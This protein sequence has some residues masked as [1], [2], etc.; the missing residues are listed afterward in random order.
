MKIKNNRNSLDKIFFHPE[1]FDS[2]DMKERDKRLFILQKNIANFNNNLGNSLG[3]ME[4][5]I[6]KSIISYKKTKK[7]NNNFLNPTAIS[8]NV[9]LNEEKVIKRYGSLE[10]FISKKNSNSNFD[11][12]TMSSSKK[13]GNDL[14][15]HPFTSLR[16]KNQK[17]VE[18]INKKQEN[19]INNKYIQNIFNTNRTSTFETDSNLPNV[20]NFNLKNKTLKKVNSEPKNYYRNKINMIIKD[21]KNNS[22]LNDKINNIIIDNYSKKNYLPPIKLKKEYILDLV[23]SPIHKN[24]L[25]NINDSSDSNFSSPSSEFNIFSE[26]N[27][28]GDNS[29]NSSK[30]NNNKSK[31]KNH[32]NITTESLGT[33]SSGNKDLSNIKDKIINLFNNNNF[34]NTSKFNQIKTIIKVGNKLNKKFKKKCFYSELNDLIMRSKIKYTQWRYGVPDA[35]KYFVDLNKFKKKEETEL[36]NRK[37][38]YEKA[39][40][41]IKEVNED[42]DKKKSVDISQKYGNKIDNKKKKDKDKEKENGNSEERGVNDLWNEEKSNNKLEEMNEALKLAEKRRIKEKEIRD[43]VKKI[44]FQCKKRVYNINNS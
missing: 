1:I 34:K 31:E 29:I 8:N 7:K 11:A 15:M 5:S 21:K 37:S 42:L 14:Y 19:L 33:N 44:M 13:G 39:E 40:I 23:H 20:K 4:I 32:I 43:K 36:E 16:I 24:K 10:N 25:S 6:P 17:L 12:I 9:N 30:K 41:I 2:F 28:H 22:N 18:K 38:F 27:T 26:E 35:E 3:N